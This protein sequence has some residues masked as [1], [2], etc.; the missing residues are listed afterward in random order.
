VK[1]PRRGRDHAGDCPRAFDIGRYMERKH[2]RT[3][4]RQAQAVPRRRDCYDERGFMYQGIVD[5]ASIR[6]WLRYPVL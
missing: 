1:K 4:L 5:L 6:I 2:R 3:L